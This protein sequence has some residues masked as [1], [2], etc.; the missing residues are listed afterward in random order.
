MKL[1]EYNRLTAVRRSG[2]GMYLGDG[3]SSVLLPGKYVPP[4]LRVG[5]ELEVFV[6]TDS[7]DRPVATTRR[8]AGTV[9]EVVGL[10][11]VALSRYGAFLDWGLEKD[12]F[13]PFREMKH[14]KMIPGATYVVRILRDAESGRVIA[15]NRFD[16][17]AR[18]YD[19]A[20]LRPGQALALVVLEKTP[21][22][23]Q[24]LA[25]DHYLGLLY[26]SEL[27]HPPQ[28]GDRLTG[29]LVKVRPD[30]KLDLRLRPPGREA[31]P[32]VCDR[33]RAELAAAADGILPVNAETPAPEIA[34]RWGWSRRLFK[35]ALGA[36]YR[37]REIELIEGGIR[38]L[39]PSGVEDL[40]VAK[41]PEE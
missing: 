15:S 32:A 36:L 38:R 25:D 34:R 7:E 5:D 17:Q 28:L 24:V 37:A 21:L 31:I 14:K 9:G 23:F 2:F 30:R 8:P 22:G 33:L 35:Q 4:G 18:E 3:E 20:G 13:V 19:P 12:L 10:R 39:D 26:D 16:R 27:P 40:P 11:A 6:Y 41:P 29:Y 1:G